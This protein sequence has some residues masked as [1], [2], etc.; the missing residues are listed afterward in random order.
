M[1]TLNFFYQKK[2]FSLFFIILL[3]LGFYFRFNYF[4]DGLWSDEWISF[5]I[6]NSNLNL[7]DKYN[8]HIAL[9]GASPINLFIKV[10]II[11]LV[12]YSYQSVEAV[13]LLSSMIFLIVSTQLY[14]NKK[15]KLFYLF[16]LSL[17]PFLIYFSGELRFYSISTLFSI[18]S[19]ISFMKLQEE[20]K[21]YRLVLFFICILLSML[22]NLYTICILF[23]YF[24]FNFFNKK[25]KLVFLVLI[26]V[27]IFFFIL[28]KDYLFLSSEKYI[29]QFGGSSGNLNS[30]FFFGYFFNIFFGDKI[31]GAINLLFFFFSIFYF[32]NNILSNHKLF[33]SYL[34]IFTTYLAFIGY[35]FIFRDIFFPRHFIFVVPFIIFVISSLILEIKINKLKIFI[36]SIFVFACIYV[37]IKAVKPFLPSKPNPEFVNKILNNSQIKNIYIPEIKDL[38][39]I[40]ETNCCNYNELLFTYSNSFKKNNFKILI[41]DEFSN[42]NSFWTICIE[43]PSFRE[44]T[45]KNKLKNCYGKLNILNNEYYIKKFYFKNDFK[46]TLYENKKFLSK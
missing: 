23:S 7:N 5:Y 36:I 2:Y 28:S 39:V 37:N 14:E 8:L 42:Y 38:N 6:A 32:K 3:L 30:K 34:I 41:N 13:Y 31:F 40:D 46:A 19:F 16:L 11:K 9:E 4:D 10:L 15:S 27:L 22:I 17:N 29:N 1:P 25:D 43:N 12:G 24:L 18:L 35:K 20:V 45:D 26:L 21:L 44:K 33:L